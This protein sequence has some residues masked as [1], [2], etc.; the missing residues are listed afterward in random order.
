MIVNFFTSRKDSFLITLKFFTIL[1]INLTRLI[2]F[3][4]SFYLLENGDLVNLIFDIRY[5]G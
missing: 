1:F 2:E 4:K 5:I 3:L